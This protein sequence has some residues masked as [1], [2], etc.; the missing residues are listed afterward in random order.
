METKTKKILA[1]VKA[2]VIIA[3]GLLCYTGGWAIFLIPNNLV[4]GGVSGLGAVIQY[5]TGFPVSYSFF[6]INLL[7]LAIALKVL[8]KGF[9]VKTVFAIIVASLAFE[10]WPKVVPVE[11]IEEMA[12]NGKL[13][14]TLIGGV[15]S[16]VGIGITF[17]QG[18]STGG[19]DIVALMVN[20]YRNIPPGRLILAIDIFIVASSL[21]IPSDEG[22]GAR[23]ATLVYGY[24]L[25]FVCGSSVDLLL[26]GTKQSIQ[27]FIFSK[28]YEEIADRITQEM[29]RGVT[30]LDGLGWFTKKEGKILMVIARKTESSM[31]MRIVR[32][33]DRDA[34]MSTGVV[35]GVYGQGFDQ[36]KK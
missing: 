32:E 12:K 3:L 22:V 13:L 11:F 10:I 15:C 2:Y 23:M 31:L 27:L 9:G 26:S 17:T 28:H 4:G 5:T 16:G 34:F 6:L 18:G 29:H 24:I 30:V 36:I 21:I 25:I 35:S 7:L 19:T 14:C 8:G 33:V 1:E 20:K